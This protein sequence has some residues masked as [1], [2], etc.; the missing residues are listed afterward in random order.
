VTSVEF[1]FVIS[2]YFVAYV[3]GRSVLYFFLF[4]S[5]SC[6]LRVG[7]RVRQQQQQILGLFCY[8]FIFF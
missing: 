2:I 3:Y 7:V 1:A 8:F 6:A 5:F 4:G